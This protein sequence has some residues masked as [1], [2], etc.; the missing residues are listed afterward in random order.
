[1]PIKVARYPMGVCQNGPTTQRLIV[2]RRCPW[3]GRN[4]KKKDPRLKSG[5]S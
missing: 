5:A 4:V 2:G 1:M 3:P